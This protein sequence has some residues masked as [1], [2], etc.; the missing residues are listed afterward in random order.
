MLLSGPSWTGLVL[1]SVEDTDD[2]VLA[3][4]IWSFAEFPY[5]SDRVLWPAAV[6]GRNDEPEGTE[7]FH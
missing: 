1:S 7:A 5:C 2:V 6:H 4:R 3:Q